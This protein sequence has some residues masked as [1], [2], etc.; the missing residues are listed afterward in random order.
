MTEDYAALV[1]EWE[2][3]TEWLT[4]STHKEAE[5][6]LRRFTPLEA[7]F[8]ADEKKPVLWEN[9]VDEIDSFGDHMYMVMRQFRYD[10]HVM[11]HHDYFEI[12]YAYSGTSTLEVD[13]MTVRLEKGDVCIL[14]GGL[15]HRVRMNSM[16]SALVK[17]FIRRSNFASC[18]AGWLACDNVLSTFFSQY[19]ENEQRRNFVIFRTGN[20]ERI[21]NIFLDLL[22][23]YKQHGSYSSMISESLI[24]LLFCHLT[25][26]HLGGI[27][28]YDSIAPNERLGDI[29][30]FIR[31][32]CTTVTLESLSEHTNYTKNYLCRIIRHYT[33]KT[34]TE[35][36]NRERVA[37]ACSLLHGQ[38]CSVAEISER[39]GFNN[40]EHFYRVFKRCMGT[41]PAQ[42]RKSCTTTDK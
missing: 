21:Q 41:T 31:D 17:V 30:A 33:G 35:L 40:V 12:Q 18:Y 27:Y 37:L 14:S 13:G 36:S 2:R 26:S 1:E 34:L 23:D 20:D 11:H 32:N 24:T 15:R 10:P 4:L 29:L 8:L 19:L 16:R 38:R 5:E 22:I 9:P 6:Y 39:C 3:N 28:T 25:R 7:R 42:Y